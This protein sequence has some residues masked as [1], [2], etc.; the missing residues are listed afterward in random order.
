MF[1]NLK[2]KLF[3]EYTF[4]LFG[5]VVV[6]ISFYGYINRNLE[7]AEVGQVI[8][9]QTFLNSKGE[10][11]VKYAFVPYRIMY[12]RP[13]KSR[14][15]SWLLKI[16]PPELQVLVPLLPITPRLEFPNSFPV[17]NILKMTWVTGGKRNMP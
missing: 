5:L 13:P 17:R 15:L 9:A 8:G 2:S 3:N 12:S 14:N 16:F 10:L 11:V 1:T 6:I 7:P 4:F